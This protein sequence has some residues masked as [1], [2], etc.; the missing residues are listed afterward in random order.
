MTKTEIAELIFDRFRHDV[1]QAVPDS[2]VLQP[3]YLDS[4]NHGVVAILGRMVRDTVVT[5]REC[6]QSMDALTVDEQLRIQRWVALGDQ[7]GV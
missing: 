1:E 3:E 5:A 6:Q 2:E 4:L 7:M